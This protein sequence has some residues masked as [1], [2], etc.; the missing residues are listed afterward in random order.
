M[1]LPSRQDASSSAAA[2]RPSPSDRRPITARATPVARDSHSSS[3]RLHTAGIRD[4][5]SGRRLGQHHLDRVAP[6]RRRRVVEVEVG[7]VVHPAVDR[8]AVVGRPLGGRELVEGAHRGEGARG[9]VVVVGGVVVDE[10]EEA[11]SAGGVGGSGGGCG[12]GEGEV[13][14]GDGGDG[15]GVRDG[16]VGVRV[17]EDVRDGGDAGLHEPAHARAGLLEGPEELRAIGSR[18]R[19]GGGR[20]RRWDG[21][22]RVASLG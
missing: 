16:G 6:A 22:D 13:D 15:R 10:V 20:H 12:E 11:P 2:P 17:A 21:D 7:G 19:E 3:S 4:A 18:R 9:V 5:R 1:T 8:S 14:D